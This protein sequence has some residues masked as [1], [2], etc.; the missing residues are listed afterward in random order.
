MILDI[1]IDDAIAKFFK[2]RRQDLEEHLKPQSR[3]ISG[4]G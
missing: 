4:D 2:G 3:D 1:S